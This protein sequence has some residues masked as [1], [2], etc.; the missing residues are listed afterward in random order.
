ML[1]S[2]ISI[3][4]NPIHS[5]G[6]FQGFPG[7]SVGKESVCSAGDTGLIPWVGKISWRREWQPTP[8]FLPGESHRWKSLVGYTVHG[9]FQATYFLKSLPWNPQLH[10]F[11]SPW[12]LWPWVGASVLA[13]VLLLLM[14]WALVSLSDF[15]SYSVSTLRMGLTFC[16]AD[17]VWP[18]VDFQEL[19]FLNWI[20]I[21]LY[22]AEISA[23]V[24]KKRNLLLQKWAF[25]WKLHYCS[26]EY[27]SNQKWHP[28]DL[29]VIYGLHLYFAWHTMLFFN[30]QQHLKCWRV[31]IKI[32]VSRLPWK[33]ESNLNLPL[34]Q[35]P[36]LIP[37]LRSAGTRLSYFPFFALDVH[38][39]CTFNNDNDPPMSLVKLILPIFKS[40]MFWWFTGYCF[41]LWLSVSLIKLPRVQHMLR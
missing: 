20:R 32:H 22:L 16:R 9:L 13:L 21:V 36:W 30:C 24:T 37:C 5:H 2:S 35:G 23:I 31:Y 26:M 41:G 8:E 39:P 25:I 38:S 14:R 34:C 4:Q 19:L 29:E 28:G 12:N 1:S 40:Y 17:R 15:V 7:D 27:F 3:C 6:L 11:L 18:M 33:K 10:C